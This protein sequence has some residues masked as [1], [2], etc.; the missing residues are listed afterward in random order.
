MKNSVQE[1]FSFLLKKRIV[2][3]C[4][5]LALSTAIVPFARA[6]FRVEV[7]YNEGWNIY[8]AS[9]V[10]DHQ[11]LYREKYAWTTVNYPMLSFFIQAQLHR[12]THEYLFTARAV[13]VLSLICCSVLVGAI[14]R[15]L[16]GSWQ[17]STLAGFYCLALFCT[18]ADIYVGMDD[19]QMFAQVFFL[20]GLLV[21]LWRRES[22]LAIAFAALLFVVGGCIKHNPIDFPLA[23][24]LEL[25]LISLRRALWFSGW[26]LFFASVA[27]ALNVHYG[28][29]HFLSQLL[30]PRGYSVGKVFDQL[31]NV[32]GPLLL[33]LCVALY[34]AFVVRK[35]ERR[36]IAAILLATTLVVGGYFGGGQGVSI[37]ALFSALLA[38]AIVVGLFC[39]EV[40]S[41]RW[42][43][44]KRLEATYAP[45]LLFGWLMIPL[46][47]SG[48]WNPLRSLRE[49]ASA[50]RRFDE[51][52][53]LL[54]SRMGPALCE[55]LLRCYFAGKPYLYDPFNAT[56]LI[57]FGKL[58]AGVIVQEVRRQR[59]GTI[60]FDEP[61]R[62]QRDSERFDPAILA[63]IEENYVLA[64]EHKDGVIYV[65]K[66][67]PEY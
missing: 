53:A 43:W 2:W 13:S 58:D 46:I 62:D 7:D 30:A 27:V 11:L 47:I 65:P 21:Y 64:L 24:L 18:D 16:S 12:L 31:V 34:T 22:L 1:S 56:R 51:D 63:A 67:K 4:A 66:T 10:A 44:A 38:M 41:A 5:C 35:D 32:F 40:A 36:R 8:N 26:G 6:F 42:R 15:R 20:A 33:P 28:G 61:I 59:Y 50:E 23:V 49:T 39:A 14:V 45:L 52:V 19:P 9:I 57:R 60:Q 17:A 3:I 25:A 55:S 37:N 54:H 48:N 29:P